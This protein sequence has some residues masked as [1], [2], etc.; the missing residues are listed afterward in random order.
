MCLVAYLSAFGITLGVATFA[1]NVV[2]PLAVGL[3]AV[4]LLFALR[5]AWLD[6]QGHHQ[7]SK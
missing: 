2:R 6:R 1:L 7:V 3:A 4:A 5:R